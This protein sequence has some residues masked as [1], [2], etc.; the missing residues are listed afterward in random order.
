VTRGEE[1]DRRTAAGGAVLRLGLNGATIPGAD[2][3]TGIGAARAGG[4]AAYEPRVP[5]LLDCE[6]R[7][8]RDRALARL[9]ASG[10]SWLPLNAL[11]EVF[12]M[13]PRALAAHAHEIFSL[14]ARF[15]IPQV[16]VVPGRPGRAV[17]LETARATLSALVGQA[18]DHGVSLCYELIG[19]PSH[20]F[21]SLSA[22]VDL[23]TGLGIPLV[24]DTFHLAVSRT[25]SEALCAL[26]PRAIGLVHLSDALTGRGRVE[27]LTDADRV[28]PGEGGLPVGGLLGAILTSGYRGPVSVEVFHPRYGATDASSVARDACRSARDALTIAWQ[29]AAQG[30]MRNKED[31]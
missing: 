16:I 26:D 27:A 9:E 1:P 28:L 11:E 15:S 5:A 24:L 17:A 31:S 22:A 3:E 2:L 10:L 7:G 29:R 14:A 25:V 30:P 19:F 8:T 18:R 4:F 12:E 13:A 21:A 6:R 20:A 23:T